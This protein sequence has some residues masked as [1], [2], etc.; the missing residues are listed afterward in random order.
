MPIYDNNGSANTLIGLVYDNNGSANSQIKYVYDSNGSAN[1]LI[2]QSQTDFYPGQTP[3]Y[4]RGGGN[5][6]TRTW[7]FCAEANQAEGGWARAY[8]LADLS[9]IRTLRIGYYY[10]V[11]EYVQLFIGVCSAFDWL[12]SIMDSNG[13]VKKK[14]VWRPTNAEQSGTVTL[15]VS[16]LSG[17]YYICV[18]VYSGSS[19][20]AYSFGQISSI[21][22]E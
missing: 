1:S 10:I 14:G 3:A 17:N 16:D 13:Y 20:S 11:Q 15:D 9:P 6:N 5:G 18:Q 12:P 19:V 7:D 2:Y 4:E 21:I 8:I 22:G